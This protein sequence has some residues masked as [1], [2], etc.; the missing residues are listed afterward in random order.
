VVAPADRAPAA[1]G[2]SRPAILD[3]VARNHLPG[4]VPAG[5]RIVAGGVR[6]P[7]RVTLRPDPPQDP[8]GGGRAGTFPPTLDR[9]L[10][11][12]HPSI[13]TLVERSTRFALLGALPGGHDSTAVINVLTT[14]IT[15]LPDQL[16][17][18]LT[19]DNGSEL[20]QVAQFRIATGCPVY[21]AD[22]HSPWQRGTNEN[23]NGLLRQYLPKGHD[24]HH[25]TQTDL[26][27]IAAELNG[28][29]RMTLDWATPAETLNHL[30][31]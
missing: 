19:W 2:A 3:G 23:T 24:L 13:V 10:A 28:R 18:S 8:A 21:F 30:L 9:G 11:H 1:P 26:D 27:T 31:H 14:L 12:L 6:H 17:R 25:V 4:A 22:P 15:A 7:G 5:P 20:A 16:R 29:P